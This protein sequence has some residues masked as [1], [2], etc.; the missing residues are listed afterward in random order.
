MTIVSQ[1]KMT[2]KLHGPTAPALKVSPSPV[3]RVKSKSNGGEMK[4]IAGTA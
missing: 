1:E 2:L 4:A 3:S